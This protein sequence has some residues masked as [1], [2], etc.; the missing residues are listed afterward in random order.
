MRQSTTYPFGAIRM[1]AL[2]K[3]ASPDSPEFWSP[4]FA[5]WADSAEN[6]EIVVI[7]DNLQA[8]VTEALLNPDRPVQAV[9]MAFPLNQTGSFDSTRALTYDAHF[10]GHDRGNSGGGGWPNPTEISDFLKGGR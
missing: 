4:R 5:N 7:V 9:T 6:A 10:G 8:R 1:G 2:S 3:L